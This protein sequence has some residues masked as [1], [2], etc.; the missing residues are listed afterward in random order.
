MVVTLQYFTGCPSWQVADE[1][2]AQ[3][4]TER[5]DLTVRYQ[6]VETVEDAERVGFHGSPSIVVDGVDVFDGPDAGVGLACR[7]YQTPDGP[8]GAPTLDQL[9]AALA[10][11]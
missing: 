10:S 4:A 7:L 6:L 9:R 1:R 11:R 8:A 3:L 5:P 2:L